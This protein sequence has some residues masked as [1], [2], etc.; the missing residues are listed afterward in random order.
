MK[1]YFGPRKT[2]F[3]IQFVISSTCMFLPQVLP[4]LVCWR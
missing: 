3:P 1:Q 2:A 4:E